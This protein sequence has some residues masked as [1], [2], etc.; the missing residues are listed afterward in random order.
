[1]R[2]KPH[3]STPALAGKEFHIWYLYYG[4]PKANYLSHPY[5]IGYVVYQISLESFFHTPMP[6]WT[7]MITLIQYISTSPN[8]REVLLL[9]HGSGI[10][11]YRTM[12]RGAFGAMVKLSLCDL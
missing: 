11:V 5:Y 4:S 10:P 1:M 9:L 7:F 3:W 2:G 6:D 12:R 8:A